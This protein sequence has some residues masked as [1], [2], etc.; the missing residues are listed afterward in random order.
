MITVADT[1][2]GMSQETSK[3]IF[4]P[5]FTTKGI[6]GTG[7]GLWVSSEIVSNHRGRIRVRS[8]DGYGTAISIFFPQDPSFG[9]L[10]PHADET[11]ILFSSDS[12]TQVESSWPSEREMKNSLRKYPACFRA[13]YE[14]IGRQRRERIFLSAR[15]EE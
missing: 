13:C 7:L 11:R 9:D 4:E 8:R 5:F 14:L 10:E 3:R 6:N 12:E 1:G 15:S 2:H